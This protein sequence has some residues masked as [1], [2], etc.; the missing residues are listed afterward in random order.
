M[1]LLVA[2]PCLNEAENIEKVIKSI[3]NQI[4]GIDVIEILVVDDGSEDETDSLARNA[5][6]T[7]IKHIQN[8]G[9]GCA[10]Q[11]A[12]A[13]ASEHNVDVMVNMDGDGQFN[14]N[15][16]ERLIQPILEKK[17][18]VVT[19]SRF[20][21]SNMIPD[22]PK[23]KLW[24]N[25]RM[26][27]IISHLCKHKYYDVS[28][29]F[30]AYS[31]ETILKSNFHGKFTYT[32]EAF[33]FFTSQNLKII[34]VPVPVQYFK[35][36]KSRV[37]GNL[38]KYSR[39]TMGI[40]L[41]LYRDYFPMRMMGSIAGFFLILTLLFGVIFFGHYMMTGFFRDYL[42]AGLTAAFTF[43]T[44]LAFLCCGI[45]MQGSVRIQENQN[46]ILYLI[47]KGNSDEDE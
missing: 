26:A 32:Q 41:S 24:G 13:Y 28:C 36:R 3:N 19:A 18:D 47:K 7:V 27:S 16:I 1:K 43:L 11:T 17:A 20:I 10:F 9:V 44:A 35:D 39:K 42:F 12:I 45:S 2:I 25:K 5:G 38:F 29:G 46:R 31:K 22:M 30:R 14:S 8:K 6:A 34:E 21:D 4:K 37:A 23:A 15:D 40:I 33:I